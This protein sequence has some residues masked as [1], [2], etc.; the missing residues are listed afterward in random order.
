MSLVRARARL[1]IA[2]ISTGLT[3]S[4][5]VSLPAGMLHTAIQTGIWPGYSGSG[6]GSGSGY[7]HGRAVPSV[8]GYNAIMLH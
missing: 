7:I 3:I 5:T 8:D 6:A 4:G 2:V 1:P